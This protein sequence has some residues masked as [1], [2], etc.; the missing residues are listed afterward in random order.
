MRTSAKL[1][2]LVVSACPL[3]LLFHPVAADD[4]HEVAQLFPGVETAVADFG[5]AVAVSGNTIAVGAPSS[6]IA[7]QD[8]GAVYVYSMDKHGVWQ[9]KATLFASDPESTK[10]FGGGVGIEDDT[11]VVSAERYPGGAFVYE[12]VGG[13]WTEA[14]AL[15]ATDVASAELTGGIAIHGKTIVV[16]A[17]WSEEEN[18]LACIFRKAKDGRW[19]HQQTIAPEGVEGRGLFGFGET[20]AINGDVIVLGYPN[21]DYQGAVYVFER[22]EQGYQQSQRLSDDEVWPLEGFGDS[23][24][25]AGE[26][27]VVGAPNDSEKEEESGSA[28]VFEKSGTRWV[29]TQKLVPDNGGYLH[30][31]GGAVAA[32]AGAIAIGARGYGSYNPFRRG[33]GTAYTFSKPSS[34]WL[35]SQQLEASD[36]EDAASFGKAIAMS[37]DLLAVGADRVRSIQSSRE[38]VYVF[39]RQ[40]AP[41]TIRVDV[42]PL[43]SR[44]QI[45][46]SSPTL[47]SVGILSD[48]DFD[49]LQTDL[50]TIRLE[51]G[52]AR[53]RNYRAYDANRDRIPDLV[54]LFRARDLRI[55]CGETEV[56]LTGKTHAGVDFYGTDVVRNRRCPK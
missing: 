25:V 30:H 41:Q 24:A 23:I 42:K 44:N 28:Y 1:Y 37:E 17:P 56:E 20:V 48:D 51:P 16:G 22:T 14:Q 31:F 11:I 12:R 49:A 32:N 50:E 54:P 4:F 19:T 55:G 34:S 33:G 2:S 36:R 53:A 21:E 43:D 8:S 39:R 6:D 47:F 29:R 7:A 3:V 45:D 27:I 40:V 35:E 26:M 38:K 46:P 13:I 52:E 18:G 9:A 10:R 15:V 5:D